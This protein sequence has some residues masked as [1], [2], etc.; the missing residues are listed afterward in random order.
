MTKAKAPQSIMQVHGKYIGRKA[1]I[2]VLDYKEVRRKQADGEWITVPATPGI[3]VP[4][5]I[6]DVRFIYGRA[7]ALVVPFRGRGST[8]VRL[9]G[10]EVIQQGST[11]PDARPWPPKKPTEIAEDEA[12]GQFADDDQASAG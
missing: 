3:Q 6:V 8:W 2:T 7:D 4:V 1:M 5:R 10:L 11:W 12:D 9:D